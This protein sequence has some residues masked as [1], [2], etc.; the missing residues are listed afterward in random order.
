MCWTIRIHHRLVRTEPTGQGRRRAV[1]GQSS[2]KVATRASSSQSMIRKPSPG[3]DGVHP[4]GDCAGGAP[5]SPSALYLRT[6][7]APNPR[8]R[9]R[10][11][12]HSPHLKVRMTS[13]HREGTLVPGA[14]A[15][16]ASTVTARPHIRGREWAPPERRHSH[17]HGR[18]SRGITDGSSV[19]DGLI[20]CHG[21]VPVAYPLAKTISAAA[22]GSR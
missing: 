3:L 5:L 10:R 22:T 21:A 15:S 18:I 4:V 2:S 9:Q 19:V 16:H 13:Q 1:A 14:K 6:H 7:L 11:A 12:R 8:A 17:C 20:S